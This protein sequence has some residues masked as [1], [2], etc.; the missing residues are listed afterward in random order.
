MDILQIYKIENLI[1]N[2]VYV[3]SSVLGI[4]KRRRCHIFHLCNNTHHSKRLQNS[5]NKYGKENF[6]FEVVEDCDKSNILEREQYWI[7]YYDSYNKGYNA[8][9]IAG[10]CEGR[11]VKES[12]RLKISKTLHGRK[13]NRTPDHNRNLSISRSRPV[14]QYDI[15]NNIINRFIST[16]SAAIS[17]GISQ[18]TVSA[19]CS[20]KQKS[21]KFNIKY[22][23]DTMAKYLRRLEEQ[24]ISSQGVE[25]DDSEGDRN[26]DGSL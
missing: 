17:L 5:W 3:G 7:N 8:T 16:T 13:I 20:G 1:T 18:S 10:N 23:K 14:I 4:K 22:E 25:G 26:E 15:N 21:R 9:P 6:K 19:N 24:A 11:Q 12:T 2:K